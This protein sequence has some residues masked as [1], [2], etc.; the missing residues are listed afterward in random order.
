MTNE[1]K[2]KLQELVKFINTKGKAVGYEY[3]QLNAPKAYWGMS[4]I[5]GVF[6]KRDEWI[7]VHQG[8]QSPGDNPASAYWVAHYGTLDQLIEAVTRRIEIKLRKQEE[9]K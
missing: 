5:C 7:F 3:K 9:S 6:K 1:E 2:K 4:S 8:Q